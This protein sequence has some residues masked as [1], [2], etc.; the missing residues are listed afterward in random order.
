MK[1]ILKFTLIILVATYFVYCAP[2]TP[3]SGENEDQFDKE[4][5]DP[6]Q[7]LLGL[8]F[9]TKSN[10]ATFFS[11]TRSRDEL[12][13]ILQRTIDMMNH[14]P[15]PERSR[16]HETYNSTAKTLGRALLNDPRFGSTSEESDCIPQLSSQE[17]YCEPALDSCE[18]MSTAAMKKILELREKG[19]SHASMKKLYPKYRR[20]K[21]D[22]YRRCVDAG[23]TVVNNIR[24]VNA[25][26]LAR[27]ASARGAGQP[28]HGYNIRRW[29]LEL[30]DQYNI[31]RRYFSASPTWLYKLKK[32]GRIGSRK[33]T[34]YISRS[35]NN[36]QDV[37]DSRIDQFLSDY[38]RIS[39]HFARRLI[40]NMDQTPF[41]Y[42][43]ANQRTLSFIGERDTRLHVDQK[44]KISH[45]F[46]AQPMIT[47]D[48]KIFGKLL[49]VLQETTKNGTFGPRIL[50][51]V[52]ELERR[53]GNIRVYASKS[54][55]LT[56]ELI[57]DWIEEVFKPAVRATLTS[58]DTDTDIGSDLETMSIDDDAFEDPPV[59]QEP[60]ERM[61]FPALAK[62]AP[63]KCY[64][65]PH[66]LLIADSWGGH[67][68]PLE[69]EGNLGNGIE[70]LEIPD[71]TYSVRK[72]NC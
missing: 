11:Q 34:E 60:L 46:T 4:A 48:G 23:S 6:D 61:S 47:R 67:A 9:E 20:D 32:T 57:R 59:E 65:K 45:S 31:S 29:G 22:H 40:I 53:Y 55:K 35:E 2:T 69:E 58:V 62:R 14:R 12:Q 37:I 52:Q 18:S 54:G 70:Y 71:H 13:A 5:E 56:A 15:L 19:R 42:E 16:R 21:L 41:D 64:T 72:L 50:P 25:G 28:V 3:R 7:V 39:Y 63:G 26:V 10:L 44:N 43:I 27:I 30:A 38:E 66:T 1:F 33:V 24:R 8:D 36:Q 51:E 68:K 49:L 17:E